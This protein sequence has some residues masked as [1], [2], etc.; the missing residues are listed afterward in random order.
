MEVAGWRPGASIAAL[1]SR[2]AMLARIREFFA[3]RGVLEVE[4]PILG[5]AAS[6]EPHLASL[7]THVQGPTGGRLRMYLQTSPEFAMKRL[8]AAGSGAIYQITRAFRDSE[9][10]TLHNP[11]FSL[12]EWYRPGYDHQALIGEVDE[13]LDAIAGEPGASR[14]ISYRDAFLRY[15]DLDPFVAG[16]DDLRIRCRAYGLRVADGDAR[17]DL[18]LDFLLEAGVVPALGAGRVYLYDFPPGGASLARV[19]DEPL[20]V[21]ERF[22]LYVDG[23]ELANGYRELQDPAEQRARFRADCALRAERGLPLVALDERLLAALSHGLP[24]CAG[25]AL[26][27]DRLLMVMLGVERLADVLAFPLDRA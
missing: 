19:R 17:R 15:L 11:E 20:P 12:L 16:D 26:G 25:V 1:Q 7:A 9:S 6:T 2:A 23:L 24:D 8:L 13:L 21:A 5:A 10:G 22:E 3:L 18:C 27:L 4:T 14:R